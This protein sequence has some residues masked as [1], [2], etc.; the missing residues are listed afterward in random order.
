MSE[1]YD[2]TAITLLAEMEQKKTLMILMQLAY[3]MLCNFACE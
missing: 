1:V 3:R 2:E